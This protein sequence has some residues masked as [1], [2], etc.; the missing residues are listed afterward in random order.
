MMIS[1]WSVKHR[2]EINVYLNG[3]APAFSSRR[4]LFWFPLEVIHL[5]VVYESL[6]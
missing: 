6:F 2:V 3:E 4:R 5:F 1:I